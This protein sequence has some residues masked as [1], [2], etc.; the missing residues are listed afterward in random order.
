MELRD[1]IK[2]VQKFF[3]DAFQR[4]N[5]TIDRLLGELDEAEDMYATMLTSHMKAVQSLIGGFLLPSS[6]LN[7]NEHFAGTHAERVHFWTLQ[8]EKEKDLMLS[9]YDDELESYKD[10]KFR[11]QK[12]L[13]CVQYGLEDEAREQQSAGKQAHLLRVDKIKSRVWINKLSATFEIASFRSLFHSISDDLASGNGN[14]ATGGQNERTLGDVPECSIKLLE[15]HRGEVQRV[16]AAARQG[17]RGHERDQTSLR[18]NC[19]DNRR[20]HV[21][22]GKSEGGSATAQHSRES[23]EEVQRNA[24]REISSAEIAHGIESEERQREAEMPC[25]SLYGR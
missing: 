24:A 19:S 7:L 3:D 15:Q 2:H 12:G 5:Q 6:D 22:E 13:E 20:D 18:R 16:R 11:A 23:V 17:Q 8:Y 4:K 9:Q 14:E 1:E 25:Y 21:A 10:R